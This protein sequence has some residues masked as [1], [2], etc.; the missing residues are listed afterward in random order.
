VGKCVICGDSTERP[1]DAA[2]WHFRFIDWEQRHWV[3]GNFKV[4]GF[5]SGLSANMSLM[6]P[7]WDTIANWRYR[8]YTLT[9]AA[10]NE[11]DATEEQ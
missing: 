9:I 7:F 2:I 5:W 3:R 4:F 6:F 1:F 10:E 11:V 8:K